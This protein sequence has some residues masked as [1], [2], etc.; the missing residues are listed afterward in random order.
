[1]PLQYNSLDQSRN[2]IRLIN[3]VKNKKTPLEISLK[4]VSKDESPRYHCLSYV[5]GNPTPVWPIVVDGAQ[6]LVTKNLGE[7]LQQIES[8][9]EVDSLWI[10][11]IC[12]NQQDEAEKVYQV[13]MMNKIYGDAIAVFAWLGPEMDSSGEIMDEISRVGRILINN[14]LR[15]AKM[16]GRANDLR[17]AMMLESWRYTAKF[18]FVWI[19][20]FKCGDGGTQLRLPYFWDKIGWEDSER[21]LSVEWWNSFFSRPYWKRVWILQELA[22]SR[23]AYILC[24]TRKEPLY[25]LFA[26]S[27]F[28]NSLSV[29]PFDNVVSAWMVGFRGSVFEAPVFTCVDKLV[30]DTDKAV[31]IVELLKDSRAMA[32]TI[33]QD[34]VFALSALTTD[35]LSININY[36]RSLPKHL[37][38]IVRNRCLRYNRQFA[39]L[40]L[41][42]CAWASGSPSWV[43]HHYRA[44]PVN[45]LIPLLMKGF[46]GKYNFGEFEGSN[47]LRLV[48]A[49]GHT[50]FAV[51][52][53]SFPGQG[54]L[55]LQCQLLGRV[56]KYQRLDT[57]ADELN[58]HQ[59]IM[60]RAKNSR[61]LRKLPQTNVMTIN[62]WL[63]VVSVLQKLILLFTG[64]RNIKL[65][66]LVIS[67][68]DNSGYQDKNDDDQD[69]KNK[70]QLLWLMRSLF[71]D[72]IKKEP[73][74]SQKFRHTYEEG[75][76]EGFNN[77]CTFS[78]G[79]LSLLDN[80]VEAWEEVY[81]LASTN[82]F[83]TL[84]V[85]AVYPGRSAFKTSD[86]YIGLGPDTIQTGDYVIILPGMD[87]PYIVRPVGVDLYKLVDEAY[88][89]GVMYGELFEKEQVPTPTWIEFC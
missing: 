43:A 32:A 88:V 12:I 21:R 52:E 85:K 15:K 56:T 3:F 20:I 10:D 8:E 68:D 77:V 71:L 83:Y 61:I 37:E 29:F 87:V 1:M 6:V 76:R 27:W 24:G 11:A 48:K 50:P 45:V 58:Q 67:Q 57:S 13:H 51:S 89:P 2:E 17:T 75:F 23:D 30:R 4:I 53:I 42:R 49:C 7:A 72:L 41:D 59:L 46:C 63:V 64:E 34:R 36:S 9:Q 78:E 25:F 66:D 40:D 69:N 84:S 14:F 81:W 44:L 54:I 79:L 38:D 33:P 86:G 73:Q 55:K 80:N 65:S 5:W 74:V 82:T 62:A 18:L 39:P 22:T 19:T 28:V 47:A 60:N 16:N 70:S 35:N 31:D 26:I